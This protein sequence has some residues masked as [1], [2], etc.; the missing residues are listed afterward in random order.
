MIKRLAHRNANVQLYTLELANALSQNCGN[1]MHKELA[2]RSFT[3]ALLRLT[4]DRVCATLAGEREFAVNRLDRIPTSKSR[5]RYWSE[6]PSGP[7]CSR[8]IR[9]WVSCTEPI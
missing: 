9:I 7:K 8:T 4:A 2:S 5:L 6:W 1:K 3:D